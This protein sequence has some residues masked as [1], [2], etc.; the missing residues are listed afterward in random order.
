MPSIES[1]ISP[2]ALE[3][4]PGRPALLRVRDTDDPAYWTA[5]S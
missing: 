3:L 5:A 4:E 2:L 1:T